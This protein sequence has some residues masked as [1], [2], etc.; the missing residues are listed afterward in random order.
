MTGMSKT[1]AQHTLGPDTLA[2][3]VGAGHSGTAACRLLHRLGARVRLL[4]RTPEHIDTAFLAWAA[5]SKV[6]ILGGAHTAEQFAGVNLIVLSPGVPVAVVRRLAP[7]AVTDGAGSPELI[8]ETELAWRQLTGEPLLGVTGTSGKTTTATLCA[9]MLREQGLNV[10]LG[11]N[12]GTPLSQY[13]LDVADGAPRADVLVL[14]L[15]SFQLQACTSL[16]PHVG[17]LLG[18]TPNHL[19][20]HADM[21]EY[22]DSKMRLFRCQ[23]AQDVAVLGAGLES[24]ADAYALRARRDI[25]RLPEPPRFPSMRLFGPHNQS[26]AETAW[27]ACREFGVS[28]AAAVRAAAA[29]APIEHRLEQIAERRGVLYVNDSKCTTVPALKVALEAFERPVLLLAGGKFKGGDLE[30][31]RD[32]LR[33]RVRAVGL[34][35]AS[36]DV[37]E[38]AWSGTVPLSYD[39]TLRQAV[40]RLSGLAEHGDVVLLA[41]ATA[42]FD[43]YANYM[44]R[45][46]DFRQIVSEVP[47]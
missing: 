39:K 42:S 27:I 33:A 5:A 2:A 4:E 24:L 34:Y 9:A 18:I 43:Q 19:D 6:D 46:D 38:A 36:R 32:L 47:A 40:Q 41:P 15:S 28:E 26:N 1:R 44:A 11:G 31:L 16:H 22:T 7:G 30:S 45:G 3:V 14:E 21:Q 37:F 17:V 10:F 20:H 23:T 25:V 35:G 29:Q 12:I 8:A 13:V